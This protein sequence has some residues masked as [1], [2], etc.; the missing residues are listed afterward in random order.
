MQRFEFKD[1]KSHKFWE[2]HVEGD[3]FTVRFG[4]HGTD[5]QTSS[6]TYPTADKAQL[7]AEKL[8]KSKTKKGYVEV[9][10]ADR[11]AP[12][13]QPTGGNPELEAP[14]HAN[15]NDLE[16]WQVYGDWLG[17]QGDPR[18]ELVNIDCAILGGKSDAALTAR[19]DALIAEHAA[20]WLG[21]DLGKVLHNDEV[22]EIE[23]KL[24]FAY[25]VRVRKSWDA[26]DA[27]S[28]GQMIRL[29]LKSDASRFLHE[30]SIGVTDLEGDVQFQDELNA[31][32]KSGKLPSLR[33]LVIGDF[34]YEECEI[35]WSNIGDVGR[36]WPVLPNLEY[37]KV[38]GGSIG[39][40]DIAH[41]K[42][43]QLVVET[44]GLPGQAARQLSEAR[45]PSLTSLEVW[46]GTENYGGSS[47]VKDLAGV[48][49]G[50][51]L[52]KLKHLGL[53]DADFQDDIVRALCTAPIV[54][55]LETLDI[56]M[57]I[58]TSEGANAM[59]EHQDHFAHL[60]SINVDR[61]WIGDAAQEALRAA[62][63]DKIQIGSQ[64]DD[65]DDYR[66]VAVGE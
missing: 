25:A 39:L 17:E 47:S 8:I 12:T 32:T 15:P 37:V 5:G 3:S 9:A 61:S 10:A 57:G 59:V 6:K 14:I 62:F 49:E 51:G 20:S 24:G 52:P 30:L 35:S 4:K 45:L 50:K 63:G 11:P 56:S 65:A 33:R 38:H 55:Q 18:G 23:W 46:L 27:P 26:E 53:Q 13:A 29:L 54:K 21:K 42:L 58:L 28:P 22:F 40:G 43:T 7:E 66:Y 1:G 64:N 48:L 44:G 2:I 36:I 16:A 19:R 34:T 60:T 41:E 31:L